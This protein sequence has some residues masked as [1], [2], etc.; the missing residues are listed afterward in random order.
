[1]SLTELIEEHLHAS[2]GFS[3]KTVVQFISALV[4]KSKSVDELRRKLEGN[5]HVSVISQFSVFV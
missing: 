2:A 4:G 5:V 1:M 3:D